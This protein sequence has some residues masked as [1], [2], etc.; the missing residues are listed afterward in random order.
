M[1]RDAIYILIAVGCVTCWRPRSIL[2]I[3]NDTEAYLDEMV[4]RDSG[5]GNRICSLGRSSL[6]VDLN[7]LY[8]FE[9]YDR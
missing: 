9:D 5:V 4:F 1:W 3:Q 2:K 7:R 8:I 6:G